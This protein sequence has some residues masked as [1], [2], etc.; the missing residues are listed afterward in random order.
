[1]S[2]SA[3]LAISIIA[4]ARQA[5]REMDQFG[6]Q[7]ERSS[8]KL[9]KLA[10]PAAGVIAGLGLVGKA[11]L[12][13][14]SELQQSTGAAQSVFGKYAGSIIKNAKA[15]AGAVGLSQSAFQTQAV[16]L[17]SQLKNLGA[18]M[19]QVAGTTTA[20]IKK[21]AD[22]AATFGGPTS[23]AVEAISSLMRG[24]SDPIERYGV[25]INQAAIQAEI[26]RRHLD[27]STTAAA[28]NAKRTAILGLLYKQ[29]AAATGQF[30]RETHTAAG[31]SEIQAAKLENARAAL[32]QRLLPVYAKFKGMLASVLGWVSRNSSAVF[33][34]AAVIA[35]L[36]AAVLVASGALKVYRA[37][38]AISAVLTG[39]QAAATGLQTVALVAQRA[40]LAVATAAQWAFNAAMSANPIA[41][42]IIALVA[43][44][45]GFLLAWKKSETFRR[46]ILGGWAAV[47][48]AM[49]AVL[50]FIKTWGPRAL[51]F[52]VPFIGIPLVIARHFGQIVGWLK[53]IWGRVTGD[54]RSFVGAT[55]GAV[56]GIPARLLRAGGAFLHAGKD[57][58]GRF[59]SGIAD[60]AKSVG[61]WAADAARSLVNAIISGLNQFLHLPW[62]IKIHINVPLA[63][64][65]DVGPYTVLPSIPLIGSAPPPSSFPH[66]AILDNLSAL[67]PGWDLYAAGDTWPATLN[68]PRGRAGQSIV[69]VVKVEFSGLVADPDGTARAI[70]DLL[71]R[72]RRR[73]TAG[74]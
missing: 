11:A 73:I 62:V 53:S 70:E 7:A 26:L 40:A 48:G 74:G 55:V 34:A 60:G 72:R 17:G 54:V 13:S 39:E 29:T 49:R 9:T 12:D 45:A 21:A 23:D 18:P 25:S 63:P 44:A 4:D 50:S 58:I 28:K 43:L 19:N 38:Q 35:G 31:A 8:G 68:V 56:T 47:V 65:I 42:V 3:V 22:L 32:G 6:N 1:M 46:I 36:A 30:A 37:I 59:F 14:A 64:D 41:L 57:L 20:L 24:E 15:A 66:P 52:L 27:T 10:A 51:I 61:G 69:E 16:L 71:D 5:R 33:T 2:G 67:K